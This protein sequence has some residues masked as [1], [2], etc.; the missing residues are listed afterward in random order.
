MRFIEKEM[1]RKNDLASFLVRYGMTGRMGLDS[2]VTIAAADIRAGSPFLVYG[3]RQNA[4]ALLA[5]DSSM[6]VSALIEPSGDY[7]VPILVKNR[8]LNEFSIRY[9][10][11]QWQDAGGGG[12]SV[13]WWQKVV[14]AWPQSGG[15]HPRYV[16]IGGY[17]LLFHIPEID[18]YNLTEITSIDSI[19]KVTAS[20]RK[21]SPASSLSPA[22]RTLQPLLDS[23]RGTK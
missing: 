3:L 23:R 4:L 7:M 15:F 6:K 14:D 16:I 18:D 1:S 8:M 19:V 21:A 12:G 2:S 17:A 13:R 9:R 20:G 10:D 5:D 22:W 11:G